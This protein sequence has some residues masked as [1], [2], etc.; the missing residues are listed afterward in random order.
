[1]ICH[2]FHSK[3]KGIWQHRLKHRVVDTDAPS[4]IKRTVDAVLLSAEQEN[5]ASNF[6]PFCCFSRW[7]L[8]FD[9]NVHLAERLFKW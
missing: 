5:M 8:G 7:G 1:M 3:I 2:P 6:H 9:T 4:Y